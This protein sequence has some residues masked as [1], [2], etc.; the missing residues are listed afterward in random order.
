M[1]LRSGFDYLIIPPEVWSACWDLCAAAELQ[2]LC[3]VCKHFRQICQPSVFR[4][5][6]VVCTMYN[7]E[8]GATGRVNRHHQMA[9]RLGLL[10]SSQHAASVRVWRFMGPS[11]P[12]ELRVR[13]EDDAQALHAAWQGVVD[14]FTST[15]TSYQRLTTLDISGLRIDVS[16]RAVM[17]SLPLLE[18]LTLWECDIVCR[19]GVLLPLKEFAL[20]GREE[21]LAL[22]PL[23]IA[24]PATL[25]RLKLAG[26]EDEDSFLAALDG[27]QLPQ[28]HYVSITL[29]A[30]IADRFFAFLDSC[31]Q[32]QTIR[33]HYPDDTEPI[34]IPDN[35]TVSSIT[36]LKSFWGPSNLAGLFVSG[37][38][39]EEVKLTRPAGQLTVHEIVADLA[40]ISHGSVPVRSLSIGAAIP[41][42]DSI[43]EVFTAIASL[44]PALQALSVELEEETLSES[45]Y[46]INS[47]SEF[48]EDEDEDG[49]DVEG[50]LDPTD[51][52]A[53][54]DDAEMAEASD[55]FSSRPDSPDAEHGERSEDFTSTTPVPGFMY[56]WTGSAFPPLRCPEPEEGCSPL[57]TF[58]H[59]LE[60]GVIVLPPHLEVLGFT[61]PPPWMVR[62]E[63]DHPYQHAAILL[64]ERLVPSLRD[65]AF[66]EGAV[67]RWERD[68]EVWV[69]R[70]GFSMSERVLRVV[71]QVWNADGTRRVG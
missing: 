70:A 46:A 40:T 38:P 68:R 8:L 42:P 37:R 35:L 56:H 52:E 1:D 19:A 54:C 66:S 36:A 31:P 57:T 33:I 13:D 20:T 2:H 28:L 6:S 43:T 59:S 15:L 4:S 60:T 14:A 27:H 63:F 34:S 53:L 47:N 21:P 58:M 69:H 61:Q 65:I 7:R 9:R 18:D 45:E 41:A 5:Q 71:S 29:T 50:A 3:L 30:V 55:S 32:L 49:S 67:G 12:S 16:F 10:A 62:P 24:S 25:R 11:H 48:G 17:E 44:F 64:L 22:N 23:E 39:V 51:S 26:E